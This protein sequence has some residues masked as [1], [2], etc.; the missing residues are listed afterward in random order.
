MDF[1]KHVPVGWKNQIRS[2]HQ[3][4]DLH[5]EKNGLHEHKLCFQ[6]LNCSQ[7][8]L[9]VDAVKLRRF[10]WKTMGCQLEASTS[11]HVFFTC[12]HLVLTG[13]TWCWTCK[14]VFVYQIYLGFF[15]TDHWAVDY[16]SSY[17]LVI[18]HVEHRVP[19]PT[20]C[21]AKRG[22]CAAASNINYVQINP[23]EYVCNYIICYQW[24]DMCIVY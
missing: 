13:K 8:E 15:T 24:F 5:L 17:N 7:K 3:M 12:A 10:K 21:M 19:R 16:H 22:S 9:G 23:P 6:R 14:F 20:R 4:L 11:K 18:L 1:Q 2:F